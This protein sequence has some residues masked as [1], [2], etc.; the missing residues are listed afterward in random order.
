MN[1]HNY[2]VTV[3]YASVPQGYTPR[4]LGS[5]PPG[6]LLDVSVAYVHDGGSYSFSV[7][8]QRG[9]EVTLISKPSSQ[10]NASLKSGGFRLVLTGSK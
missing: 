1:Q 2:L 9:K 4:L 5:I 7:R 3:Y 8:N 6:G 10:V